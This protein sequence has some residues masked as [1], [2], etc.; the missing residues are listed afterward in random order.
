MLGL[1][2]TGCNTKNSLMT[3]KF[4]T[5]GGEHQASRMHIVLVSQQ[6]LEVSDLGVTIFD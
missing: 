2:F 6:I 3:I 4:K 1:A 5:N